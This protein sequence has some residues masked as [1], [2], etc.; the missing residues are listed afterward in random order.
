MT[1][2]NRNYASTLYRFRNIPSYLSKFTN[3]DL[4]HLHL[5]PPLRLTAFEFQKDFW[6]HKTRVPGH[7]LRHGMFS[8]FSR[9]PTCD[10]QRQ[11]HADRH[12]AMAYNAQSIARTVK[13]TA[14][15]K[16]AYS[17]A[18]R[19]LVLLSRA[20]K[21]KNPTV[22]TILYKSTVRPP[23]EFCLTAWNSHYN[24]DKFLLEGMQHHF[25]GMFP[26]LRP[27]SYENKIRQLG[28]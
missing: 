21:Y 7:C 19:M 18:N 22:L 16:D 4:P 12:G 28:L 15:C 14:H 5:A 26:H 25:T 8:H 13:T 23:L 6:H 2:F 9:T 1:S 24:K 10:R 27:L 17:K 20:R 3:F 11:T